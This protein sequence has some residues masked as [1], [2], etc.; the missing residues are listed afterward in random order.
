MTGNVAA[1]EGVADGEFHIFDS[2]RFFV[3]L[4]AVDGDTVNPALGFRQH[5][6][7]FFSNF[8]LQHPKP[9]KSLGKCGVS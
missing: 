8:F 9:A 7:A 1:V 6:I 3:G 2:A 4:I 5:R